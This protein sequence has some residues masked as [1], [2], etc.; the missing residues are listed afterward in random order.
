MKQAKSAAPYRNRA[1]LCLA[2]RFVTLKGMNHIR[3]I[4][5]LACAL[6]PSCAAAPPRETAVPAPHAT[7]VPTRT[8]KLPLRTA[9]V[10][11][12]SG[13]LP[14]ASGV[15]VFQRGERL[16]AIRAGQKVPTVLRDKFPLWDWKFSPDGSRIA[17]SALPSDVRWFDLAD[18]ARYVFVLAFNSHPKVLLPA[19]GQRAVREGVESTTP[20][21][22]NNNSLTVSEQTHGLAGAP[23]EVAVFDV[24]RRKEV[25]SS[26]STSR[27]FLTATKDETNN[28]KSFYAP[29]LSPD[30][31]DVICL[32]ALLPIG[33]EAFSAYNAHR[34]PPVALV[35]FNRNAKGGE[36]LAS[37]NH[38]SLFHQIEGEFAWHP[39]KKMVAFVGSTLPA[40]ATNEVFVFDL[41]R[42]KLRQL[43]S[44]KKGASCPCWSPD[45]KSILWLQAGCIFRADADGSH[46]TAILPQIAGVTRIQLLPRIANWGRYRA[47]AIEALA[48]RDK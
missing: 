46:A 34:A 24:K 12:A 22:S 48:G 37:T 9:K 36:L 11:V 41:S 31:R 18:A 47:L 20:S 26:R 21:W 5:L 1:F 33:T 30:T 38:H 15:L 13:T 17:F 6:L 27:A 14:L 45:G 44:G 4:A 39:T 19:Y 32:A 28:W 29:A 7:S 10:A 25:W 23:G 8:A 42:K 16:E 43:T 35:H 2:R 3:N 40:A